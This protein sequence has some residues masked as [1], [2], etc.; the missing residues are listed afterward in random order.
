MIIYRMDKESGLVICEIFP[1]LWVREDSMV[2]NTNSSPMSRANKDWNTGY[3]AKNGYCSI[4]V[5]SVDKVMK[6]HRLV[7]MAFLNNDSNLPDIDHLNGVRSDNRI[8][9]LRWVSTRQNTQ[10][11][12]THRGG[13]L[14]GVTFRNR[15]LK[16][17]WLSRCVVGGIDRHLGYYSTE[18]E[19]HEA[20]VNFVKINNL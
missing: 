18:Q 6:V 2:K 10:N 5:P 4:R 17:P 19:A 1:H 15:G 13:K 7:A 9:N 20:Y 16:K 11:K 12:E 3:L 14:P 8:E